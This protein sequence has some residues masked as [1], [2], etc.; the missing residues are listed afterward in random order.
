[1]KKTLDKSK[2]VGQNK[3]KTAETAVRQQKGVDGKKD[4]FLPLQ[5]A[6]GWCETAGSKQDTSSL[7]R[8]AE[9]SCCYLLGKV[10]TDGVLPLQR[11]TL[12]QRC[13]R[14]GAVRTNEE[15]YQ[16]EI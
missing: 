13:D 14:A 15:W 5:R 9:P 7:S 12:L 1:M 4:A 10:G 3:E 11:S 8:S 16:G 6:V 2:K